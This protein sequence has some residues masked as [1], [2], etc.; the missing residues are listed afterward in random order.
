VAQSIKYS[1]LK[2]PS[3]E[4]P[5]VPE[6]TISGTTSIVSPISFGH[7]LLT[8]FRRD[9]KGDFANSADI[10][11]VRSNLRQVLYTTASSANTNGELPWRPEFG[12]L[13]EVL[14]FRSMDEV[15]VELARTYLVDAIKTWLPRIR[16]RRSNI[17]TD[18]ARSLLVITVHY[19]ILNGARRSVVA[20]NLNDAVEVQV[21]A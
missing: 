7:G 15:T 2:K 6:R 1:L 14:R 11:L 16:I 19:D 20:S 13:F 18:F 3:T 21:A 8:P 12:S 10:E 9:G 17:E 5:T 4:K